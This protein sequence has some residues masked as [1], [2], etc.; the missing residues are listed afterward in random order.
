VRDAASQ[1]FSHPPGEG[2]RRILYYSGNPV[3]YSS[4]D[5]VTRQRVEVI[6]HARYNIHRA[7]LSQDGNWLAFHVPILVE[8]GGSPIFIA[9]LR[10]GVARG[11]GEGSE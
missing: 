5:A 7:R 4:V 9:P 10:N 6:R 3:Y 2:R 11:E 8:E 1:C